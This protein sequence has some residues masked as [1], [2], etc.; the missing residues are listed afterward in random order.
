MSRL[1]PERRVVTAAET[2]AICYSYLRF[3]SPAQADG[4]SVRR[5]TALRDG[6]LKRHPAVRLDTSL[7][8]EDR[9]V[10]G[11][12][13]EHRTNKRHALASFLDLVERGRVPAG[14]YLIVE[15]LDR[16]TREEP[17][18][19][20]PLVM[21]LIRAGVRVVQL[22]PAEMVYEPGMDFGR[23]MMMLWELARGH[24]ESKRKSGLCGDAW[25]EKKAQA[26]SGHKAH[27]KSVP[28]WLELAAGPDGLV[29]RVKEDAGAAVRRMFQLSIEGLGTLAIAARLNALGVPPIARGKK[30]I[31]SYVAKVLDNRAVLGEYQPM[32]GHRKRQPDGDPIAG[33][34]PAVIS[35]ADWHRAH[36]ATQARNKRS[37]R[38]GR[39]GDYRHVFAGLLRDALDRCALH[40]ITRKGRR[41][42]LSAAA[43][44]GEAAALGW[45]PFPL[46]PFVQAILGQLRELDG[47]ELFADAD[48]KRVT[49]LTGR[50][51]QVEKRLAVAV[52][53]FDAEPDNPAWAEQVSRYG[54]ERGELARELALA[55]QAAANPRA[56]TWTEVGDFIAAHEPDR[57]RQAL[58]ATVDEICCVFVPRGRDRLAEVVVYF[59]GGARRAYFLAYRQEARGAVAVPGRLYVSSLRHP[60]AARL[61]LTFQ[62]EDLRDRDEAMRVREFLEKYPQAMI[63][64]LLAA[65]GQDV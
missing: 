24:A 2:T 64:K 56:G 10:S 48:A 12:R 58:L 37:G 23:L 8:L 55:R 62:C 65:N 46:L 20:I 22:A 45:R 18:V 49:E 30:W 25:G 60:D 21:N 4:D 29:Y 9:G 32:K 53:H 44:Q 28:A 17:E 31:R 59:Q 54:R 41:Y 13:G 51:G 6:W 39:K 27:G 63:D 5:Q 50:L 1:A 47:S 7:R 16:L 34:F 38:P 61:G 40:V 26:R 42:L 36:A 35:E 57:L 19:S 15:N 14:S 43:A 52:K 11:Y 3:S 33:Y